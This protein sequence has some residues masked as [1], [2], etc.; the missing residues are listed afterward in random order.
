MTLKLY[1]LGGLAASLCLAS[2]ALA[3]PSDGTMQ[4]TRLD[5][6]VFLHTS[7]VKFP[8]GNFVPSNG[9]VVVD[10]RDAYL[11][12]SP[13][14]V[15]DTPALVAWM[16]SNG[17]Q[18]RAAVA[19][20]F[21]DDRASGFEY[22]NEIGVET[23]ASELTNAFLREAG[24]AT[25]ARQF[26][27]QLTLVP[28]V[29]ELFYA[30]PGHTSDNV[31]AW[32]PQERLL[33]G[34]CLIKSMRS[35]SLGNVEDADTGQWQATLETVLATFP[36]ADIVVPGHGEPGGPELISHTHELVEKALTQ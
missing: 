28:G 26:S 23:V 18:L 25:A 16:K 27:G 31:V 14:P 36:S 30:G 13:W 7:Y 4:I 29:I 3:G 32:L 21:H 33:A 35:G 2:A 17:L 34:G 8:S 11:I 24:K 20:H 1:R 10:G 9:L 6:T 12:D 5:D 22:L 19:T 15:T